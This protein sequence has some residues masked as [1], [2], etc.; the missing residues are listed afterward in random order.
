M[1]VAADDP[2]ASAVREIGG[3]GRF[4]AVHDVAVAVRTSGIAAKDAART[5]G[6]ARRAVRRHALIS[7]EPA[8]AEGAGKVR[9]TVGAILVAVAP[10]RAA[11]GDLA[12]P[13]G[14]DLEGWIA[15]D[16]AGSTVAWVGREARLAAVHGI[17]VAVGVT[18]RAGRRAAAS[19]AARRAVHVRTGNATGTAGPKVTRQVR[20]T[21]SAWI[22]IAVG[23]DVWY[24]GGCADACGTDGCPARRRALQAA[25]A[26]VQRVGAGRGLAAVA[27]VAIAVGVADLTAGRTS[28]RHAFGHAMRVAAAAGA[29]AV[30]SEAAI[31]ERR[32]GIR[33]RQQLDP[34]ATT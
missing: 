5:G 31:A 1:R 12:A 11:H 19:D 16:A 24:T 7:A 26:T 32:R 13:A 4:A 23:G 34:H 10:P 20:L 25:P 33:Q 21:A 8:A 22:A 9:L 2:A 15:G 28:P 30:R 3:Q 27:D 29:A 18:G 17:A 14:A 6:A